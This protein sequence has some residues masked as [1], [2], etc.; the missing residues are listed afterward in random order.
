MKET[1]FRFPAPHF[2][3]KFIHSFQLSDNSKNIRHY[4]S[5][6]KQEFCNF[7]SFSG[8]FRFMKNPCPAVRICAKI[9]DKPENIYFPDKDALTFL[10]DLCCL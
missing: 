7:R 6:E 2:S 9:T 4:G 5:Y 8:I 3:I 10:N 1:F